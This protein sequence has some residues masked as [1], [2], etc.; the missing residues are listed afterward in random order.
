MGEAAET[1]EGRRKPIV[2]LVL[3]SGGLKPFSALPLIEF[4]DREGIDVDLLV[5]ASG[6]GIVA[7]LRAMGRTCGEIRELANEVGRKR[8][9]RKDWRSLLSILNLPGGRFDRRSGLFKPDA[10][11]DMCR[12]CYGERRIEELPKKLILQATDFETG[13]GVALEQGSLA[14]A[15]YASM[16]IHPFLPPIEIGGRWLFDGCFSAPVPIMPAVTH[17]ADVILVLEVLENLK[18]PDSGF[19]SFMIHTNKITAQTIL[20][21]QAALSVMLH[22]YEIVFVKVRFEK[23]LHIWDFK[24]MPYIF[25]AGEAATNKYGGEILNAIGSYRPE[26]ERRPAD[27]P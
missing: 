22:H 12:E 23:Y 17:P 13:Q 19:Q 14:D 8:V 5:G 9:F 2:A 6:G 3:A 21:N 16:A 10:V 26:E 11:M 18:I 24:E 1:G 7:A 4:L 27:S 20:R 25:E 15:V